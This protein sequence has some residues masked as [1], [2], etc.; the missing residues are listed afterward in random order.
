MPL[1]KAALLAQ[2]LL[3]AA[4]ASAQVPTLTLGDAVRLALQ[5]NKDLKVSSYGPG[6]SRADLLVARGAFDPSFLLERTYNQTQFGSSVGLVGVFD[7]EKIDYYQGGVQG[8]LPVGTQYSIYGSTTET[9]ETYA[10]AFSKNYSSFGGFQVTQPLLKGFGLGYNLENVRIAK[11]NRAISDQNF[12]QTAI[13]TVSSVVDAYINLQLAHDLFDSTLRSVTMAQRLL[14]ENEKKFKLGAA[15]QSDLTEARAQRAGYD[16]PMIAAERQVRDAQNNLRELIGADVFFEDEPLFVLGPI[17]L[18][19]VRVDP[20]ADLE[21]ALASR[22]DYEIWRQTIK[23]DRAVESW[24]RNSLLPEVNFVGGY[25]YN[26]SA[27]NFSPSR[28][29]VENQMNPS[30]SAG[31]VVTIPFTFAVGRGTLRAAKLTREQDEEN[32]KDDAANVALAVATAD[33]QVEATRKRVAADQAW[34]TF[35]RQSVED[36]EKMFK[37][38]TSSTLQVEQVQ[39]SES[40]AET[41][42]AGA[43]AQERQAIVTYDQTLGTTLERY[44]VKLAA[45]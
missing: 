34:V 14:D 35:A 40:E 31:L 2:A 6:I 37:A 24:A 27:Q 44:H 21:T 8:L 19:D 10:G 22:P 45:D 32:L 1:R 42:L 17:S 38:G 9:R 15:A 26:G 5:N 20:R 3:L 7:Q 43:V 29:M 12:R 28:Q 25:G 41:A 18:P 13:T 30:M 39:V 33:G 11:A 36:E 23:K 16:D 4:A